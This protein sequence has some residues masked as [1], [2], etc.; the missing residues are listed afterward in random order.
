MSLATAALLGGSASAYDV[1]VQGHSGQFTLIGS[2]VDTG[3][4]YTVAKIRLAGVREVDAAGVTV[5]FSNNPA[6]S[7]D[8]FAN[9][10]F[11]YTTLEG[12]VCLLCAFA[13]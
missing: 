4:N 12:C 8:T 9:Q 1:Q 7:L 2:Y 3:N 5:G 11:E 6:H 13:L 10:E